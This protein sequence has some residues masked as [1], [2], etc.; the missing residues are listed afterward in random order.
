[1]HSP[2]H[3][4]RIAPASTEKRYVCE[5]C[6]AADSGQQKN[7]PCPRIAPRACVLRNAAAPTIERMIPLRSWSRKRT[8]FGCDGFRGLAGPLAGRAFTIISFL[9]ISSLRHP[10]N[11]LNRVRKSSTQAFLHGT[12]RLARWHDRA[13]LGRQCG[14]FRLPERYRMAARVLPMPRDCR[15]R[16]GM[17][18]PQGPTTI[19]EATLGCISDTICK[20]SRHAPSRKVTSDR[21]AVPPFA[22]RRKPASKDPARCRR[23]PEY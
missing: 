8:P 9:R 19:S 17:A 23:T 14:S 16:G 11:P 18:N 22:M 21:K 4:E 7:Q 1:M 13:L 2:R 6:R 20:A 12:I 3:V 10:V 15:H 5:E